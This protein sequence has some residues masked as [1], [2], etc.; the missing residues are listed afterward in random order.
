MLV[1]GCVTC[2]FTD[3]WSVPPHLRIWE[4]CKGQDCGLDLSIRAS[5]AE[6]CFETSPGGVE[7]FGNLW[8]STTRM[9]MSI[10]W[11]PTPAMALPMDIHQHPDCP[12]V[13]Q[14]TLDIVWVVI[15]RI[16]THPAQQKIRSFILCK[17]INDGKLIPEFLG[18]MVGIVGWPMKCSKPEAFPTR[19]SWHI[20]HQPISSTENRISNVSW[21]DEVKL[22]YKV[23]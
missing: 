16:Y 2:P 19:K 21:G 22:L 12:S 7:F 5:C 20:S 8:D 17:R 13:I 9:Q 11:I 3:G 15:L 1:F 18:L 6:L 4:V 23:W 10:T 14:P